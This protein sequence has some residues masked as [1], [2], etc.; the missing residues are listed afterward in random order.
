[1]VY[2][3]V[4]A[5]LKPIVKLIFRPEIEGVDL[6]P[7]SGGVI[8]ASNHKSW[9]DPVVLGIVLKRK[10]RFIAKEELFRIPLLRN[11]FYSLGA[12]PV[13]RGSYDR[14]ALRLTLEILRNGEVLGIFVEGTRVKHEGIGQIKQGVYLIARQAGVPVV[15]ALIKGSRPLFLRKFPPVPNRIKIR[16]LPFDVDPRITDSDTYLGMMREE[17]EKNWAA[18]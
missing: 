11:L 13:K 9:I 18:M 1:M 8:I 6:I 7:E 14:K 2:K 16:F 17:L 10:I 5:I 15:L 4:R 3:L 12:F